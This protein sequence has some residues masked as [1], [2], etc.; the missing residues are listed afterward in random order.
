MQG[1]EFL[2]GDWNHDISDIA[3]D[4]REVRPGSLF[5]ALHGSVSDGHD[6]VS[7]AISRGAGALLLSRPVDCP[8]FEGG[9][10]RAED[11]GRLLAG[12]ARAWFADPSRNLE[13]TGITGTNGKT[14][15]TFLIQ[16]ILREAGRSA[17]ILGTVGYF[18]GDET[19]EAPNTTPDVLRLNRML[20]RCVERRFRDVVMEVSSH[21]LKLDRVDGIRFHCGIFTNLTQDHLDFHS[22]MEDYFQAKARLF[23]MTSG[24]GA[25]N[26]DDAYGRRL[27]RMYP[28]LITFGDGGIV[29]ARNATLSMHGAS[30]DLS[31]DGTTVP[32]RTKLVGRPN[33][34]N[35]LAAASAAH[36]LGIDPAVIARGLASAQSPRGRFELVSPDVTE[37]R[38]FSIAVDYAHTP[39]ALERLLKTGRDLKPGRL[40]AVFGCGG[41]RD[42]TKRPIMGRLASQLAD[43]V[44]ITSDNPRTEDP[45][46]ILDE[47]MTGVA[48]PCRRMVDRREAIHSAVAGMKRGDLLLIAGKGHEDYQIIGRTKKHFDDREVAEEALGI[49]D[50][51]SGKA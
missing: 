19:Y 7:D 11:P 28:S 38:G 13:I 35:G 8:G 32:V 42:R 51:E 24:R 20:A 31:V 14:T 43:E 45:E 44:W 12:I 41:D 25:V 18:I 47:I 5:I 15:T 9:V 23:E 10:I 50:P 4:S 48:G 30:F 49:S 16:S 21:A 33:I 46:R 34:S 2:R 40:L 27:L 29:Q 6:H 17:A 26:I 22:D 1:V 39:D 36:L 37:K 3:I